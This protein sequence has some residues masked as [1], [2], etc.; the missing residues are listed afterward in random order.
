MFVNDKKRTTYEP[1]PGTV[2]LLK[3]TCISSNF[4]FRNHRKNHMELHKTYLFIHNLTYIS[5]F[6]SQLFL[7]TFP[8]SLKCLKLLFQRT[9]LKSLPSKFS[10]LVKSYYLVVQSFPYTQLFLH[11][12]FRV[13]F[14]Q[15]SWFQVFQGLGPGSRSRF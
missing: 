4:R 5:V 11:L 7:S 2:R 8:V 13:Q 1:R 6:H 15:L 9:Y 12:H 10:L 3:F 14:S